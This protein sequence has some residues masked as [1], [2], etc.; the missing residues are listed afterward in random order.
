[1]TGNSRKEKVQFNLTV[2]EVASKM[3]RIQKQAMGKNIMRNNQETGSSKTE[4][5]LRSHL[6]H[7]L[8]WYQTYRN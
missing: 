5:A 8:L 3:G 4:G 7:P 1:M 2:P 6:F